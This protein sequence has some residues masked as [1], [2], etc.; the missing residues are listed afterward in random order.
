MKFHSMTSSCLFNRGTSFSQTVKYN[1]NAFLP[2]DTKS[3]VQTHTFCTML[4]NKNRLTKQKHFTA[5]LEA[6]S[7]VSSE[8]SD[9]R[10]I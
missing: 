3:I 5:A 2:L 1:N 4:V 8:I 7:P 9:L 6:E 10:N